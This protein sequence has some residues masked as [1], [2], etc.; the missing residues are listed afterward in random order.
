VD[1]PWLDESLTNYST[2]V[3]WEA[4]AGPEPAKEI[5]Q[6]FFLAPYEQAKSQGQDRAV[7][8]SVADFSEGEYG[9]IVYGKGPLFFNALRQ[10]VG[11]ETYFKI[12]QTYFAEY[13]YKIAQPDDLFAIIEQ[14]SGRDV[15]SLVETWLQK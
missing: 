14:V 4:I 6:M 12:M 10:E 11:D 5:M 8:G 9:A 15:E 13:K 3:Y 1:T 7:M 2:L